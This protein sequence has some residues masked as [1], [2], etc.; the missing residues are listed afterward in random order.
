MEFNATQLYRGCQFY[1]WMQL[2][3]SEKTTD[4]LQVATLS[5]NQIMFVSSAT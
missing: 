3:Y 1:W 5:H 2:E 4:L